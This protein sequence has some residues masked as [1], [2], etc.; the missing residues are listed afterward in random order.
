MLPVPVVYLRPARLQAPSRGKPGRPGPPGRAPA[1]WG[2]AVLRS[3][4]VFTSAPGF[5]QGP[6]G[7]PAGH[8]SPARALESPKAEPQLWVEVKLSASS[9][10]LPSVFLGS[11]ALPAERGTGPDRWKRH[12][13]AGSLP[14]GAS[15]LAG[16]LYL[17]RRRVGVSELRVGHGERGPGP[18][19]GPAGSCAR[20]PAGRSRC[21]GAAGS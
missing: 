21:S 15:G 20:G 1:T 12:R 3:S 5:P 13:I 16:P 4:E 7:P 8:V 14:A 17:G 6:A 9:P 2:Q 10:L 18:A 19:G 11:P